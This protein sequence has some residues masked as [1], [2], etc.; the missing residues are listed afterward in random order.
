VAHGT[1]VLDFRRSV[2]RHTPFSR[3][4]KCCLLFYKKNLTERSRATAADVSGIDRH[5]G[6]HG[7]VE[8]SG[9]ADRKAGRAANRG[10]PPRHRGQPNSGS[11][12]PRCPT[13]GRTTKS[14]LSFCRARRQHRA[15]LSRPTGS[16]NAFRADDHWLA[17]LFGESLDFE[18]RGRSTADLLEEKT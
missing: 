3:S 15:D 16:A 14:P 2:C 13:A 8:T 11:R 18:W 17:A 7:R 10:Q 12:Q 5:R 4:R 9:I 6:W 1:N